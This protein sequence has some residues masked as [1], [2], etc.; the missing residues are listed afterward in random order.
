MTGLHPLSASQQ[1]WKVITDTNQ[2]NIPH[3]KVGAEERGCVVFSPPLW[4]ETVL[5]FIQS[6]C[7]FLYQKYWLKGP[8]ILA[9]TQ[10]YSG[11]FLIRFGYTAHGQGRVW[12]QS[13]H[14]LHF[15][16][17]WGIRQGN[18][19]FFV[20]PI[21]WVCLFFFPLDLRHAWSK[22][23]RMTETSVTASLRWAQASLLD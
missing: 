13:P 12:L 3:E 23:A 14:A 21:P 4:H 20:S 11:S 18:C 2:W 7:W 19:C 1:P 6:R 16:I 22:C 15:I 17:G 8:V 9:P 5:P 10:V